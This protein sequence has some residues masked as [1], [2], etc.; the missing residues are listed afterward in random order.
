MR[1]SQTS[2]QPEA[3]GRA[4]Y[5]YCIFLKFSHDDD[6][7]V[8]EKRC[9]IWAK[10]FP[11]ANTSLQSRL[12]FVGI[13]VIFCRF[14]TASWP[15]DTLLPLAS[16]SFLAVLIQHYDPRFTYLKTFVFIVD[17]RT[18]VCYNIFSA[19]ILGRRLVL[20][21]EDCDLWSQRNLL[22]EILMKGG[23]VLCWQ[24]SCLFRSLA[25]A[26]HALRLDTQ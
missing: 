11:D 22:A 21:K 5:L 23:L 2:G 6:W 13:R 19:T 12:I 26:L 15:P 1:S 7:V 8:L 20:P 9:I 3:K 16:F 24:L 10:F 14:D 25:C 17:T 4:T 18:N